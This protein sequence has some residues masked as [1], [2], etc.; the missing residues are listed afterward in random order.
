MEHTTDGRINPFGL[1]YDEL[2][3]LY[4]RTA[5]LP[6]LYQLIRGGRLYAM[7]KRR[8][9]GLAPDMTPLSD[10]ATAL[11]GIGYYAD[12]HFPEEYR[13]NF[14]VGDVV[15]CRVY[16]YSPEFKGSS[17]I[18]KRAPDFV[19][20]EDPWFRPVDVKMGT[21]RRLVM[22]LIFYNSIIGHYEV[23]LDHPKRDHVR[24]RDLAHH[25]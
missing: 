10:E 16:R 18:G 20:S 19:L 6:P 21:G 2:G 12:I 22:L 7:G 15:R 5:R 3:Y 17:P 9:K 24:G 14:Y 4:S 25:L 23:P 13:K 8:R 11:A 1:V